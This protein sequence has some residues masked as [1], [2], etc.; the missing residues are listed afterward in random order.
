MKNEYEKMQ[1]GFYVK[2]KIDKEYI[3]LISSDLDIRLVGIFDKEKL[4]PIL[5]EFSTNNKN[6]D[7][8]YITPDYVEIVDY[9]TKISNVSKIYRCTTEVSS[10]YL[11]DLGLKDIFSDINKIQSYDY[12]IL[13]RN[14]EGETLFYNKN[15]L[16]VTREDNLIHYKNS[17]NMW[18]PTNEINI[19]EEIFNDIKE[20]ANDIVEEL[21]GRVIDIIHKPDDRLI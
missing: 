7:S 5:K 15:T 2:I 14:F 12:E 19:N 4:E 21:G 11:Y 18:K 13:S 20:T 1:E 3:D 9:A 16:I 8:E 6:N 17:N 10:D